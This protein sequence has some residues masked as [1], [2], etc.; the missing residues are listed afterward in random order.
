ME[1]FVFNNPGSLLENEIR[2]LKKD[3]A[4]YKTK[5]VC[6]LGTF[7]FILTTFLTLQVVGQVSR[8]KFEPGFS[9]LEKS[10]PVPE[11]FKDAKFGIYFHWGEYSVPAFA[12]EWYPRNMYIKNSKQNKHHIEI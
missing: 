10:N 8:Q 11:W 2:L 6:L 1:S 3:D 12:N 5:H 9:S 7:F 4:K